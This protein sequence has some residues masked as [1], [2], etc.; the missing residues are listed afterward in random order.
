MMI[1]GA[2]YAMSRGRKFVIDSSTFRCSFNEGFRDYW[3][4]IFP[5]I[6][7]TK[8]RWISSQQRF[9]K[10]KKTAQ[11]LARIPH[12]LTLTKEDVWDEI[13][14][15]RYNNEL[16]NWV[17][18]GVKGEIINGYKCLYGILFDNLKEDV[19]SEVIDLNQKLGLIDNYVAI[20]IRKG[21]KIELGDTG[22]VDIAVEDYLNGIPDRYKDTQI[23]VIADDFS[24]YD[25]I[26][27]NSYCSVISRVQADEKGYRHSEF[28]LLDAAEK[29]RKIIRLIADFLVCVESSYFIGTYSSNFSRSVAAFRGGVNSHSLDS[30]FQTW[31][32]Y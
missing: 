12:P 28:V 3:K 14:S 15:E 22:A 6:N 23:F 19:E 21:D 9:S 30:D 8:F 7:S 25:A 4:P 10:L 31:R 16:L 2:V 20:Q 17:R 1:A 13:V 26:K 18:L 27:T 5:E 32:N 29:R 11:K 24:S